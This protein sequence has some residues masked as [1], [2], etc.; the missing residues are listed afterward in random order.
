MYGDLLTVFGGI[1]LI[2]TLVRGMI[3]KKEVTDSNCPEDVH[4]VEM[5]KKW[6]K[7]ALWVW[8][9]VTVIGLILLFIETYMS[10]A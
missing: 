4:N 8:G 5:N 9:S 3:M 1:F 2:L 7:I 10:N 6:Y